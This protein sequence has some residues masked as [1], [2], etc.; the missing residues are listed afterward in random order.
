MLKEEGVVVKVDEQ[1]AWI[2]TQRK[3]GCG[4]CSSN[5]ECGTAS[6]AQVL[7]RKQNHLK[8]INNCAAKV[9]DH[10]IIGLEEQALV[11]G[12]LLLYLLP[13]LSLFITALGYQTLA[14]LY[15]FL[16]SA[17]IFTALAGLCGLLIGLFA[18]ERVTHKLANDYQ[19]AILKVE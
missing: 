3:S 17:E 2:Q 6:L 13:I 5:Q 16:P 15:T 14:T 8:V 18:V 19:P 10:V 7:G 4:H 9:G 1:F 12:A 11:K